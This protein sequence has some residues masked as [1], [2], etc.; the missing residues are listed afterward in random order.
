M[1]CN[2]TGVLPWFSH[3][4]NGVCFSCHGSGWILGRGPRPR[5]R[6]QWRKQGDRI[7]LA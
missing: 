4:Q 3:I 6:K 5:K 7:V 1:G 2:G